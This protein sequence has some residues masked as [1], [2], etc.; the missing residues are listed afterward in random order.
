MMHHLEDLDKAVEYIESAR[1]SG[2]RAMSHCWYGRNRSV[3]LLVAYL[4][5]YEGMTAIEANE[6]IKQT[7]HSAAPYFDVLKAYSKHYLSKGNSEDQEES[8]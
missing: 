2:G 5:K 4:M 8:S 1:Q 6:L 3:T 7:R